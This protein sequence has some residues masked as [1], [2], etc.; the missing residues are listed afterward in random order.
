M[1]WSS[2]MVEKVENLISVMPTREGDSFLDNWKDKFCTMQMSIWVTF[3]GRKKKLVNKQRDHIINL[4]HSI[5]SFHCI[6]FFFLMTLPWLRECKH[7]TNPLWRYLVY[8]L[9]SFSLSLGCQPTI[10]WYS[11]PFSKH[12]KVVTNRARVNRQRDERVEAKRGRPNQP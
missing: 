5:N 1:V 8:V 12:P 6:R 2:F 3:S 4:R 9:L 11:P 7:Q 10:V